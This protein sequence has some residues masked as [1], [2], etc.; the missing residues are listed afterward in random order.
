MKQLFLVHPI[1]QFCTLLVGIFNVVTGMTRKGFNI[2]IHLNCGILYYFSAL[3]GAGIGKLVV[4]W[5]G[6]K[7]IIVLVPVHDLIA[8]ALIFLFAMGAT[9]GLVMMSAAEK[10]ARLI[11]YH[12][13][14]NLVGITLFALQGIIGL[15]HLAK[16]I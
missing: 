10:R 14:V 7:D 3:I 13:L 2:Y 1:G 11:K 4:K 8:M 12:R 9:T 16:I 5:A 6:S 15:Y